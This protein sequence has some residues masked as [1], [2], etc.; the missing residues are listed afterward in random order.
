MDTKAATLPLSFPR[1]GPDQGTHYFIG[2]DQDSERVNAVSCALSF[3]RHGPDQGTNC[4]IDTYQ[5]SSSRTASLTLSFP[6]QGPDTTFAACFHLFVPFQ[7]EIAKR[8]YAVPS[9]RPT[10]VVRMAGGRE[11]YGKLLP[12]RRPW[13]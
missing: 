12:V 6:Q 9:V 2:N 1:H 5:K 10:G 7:Y 11:A 3:P 8:Y 4:T 13:F